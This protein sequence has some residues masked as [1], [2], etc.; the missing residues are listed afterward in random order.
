V[1]YALLFL[2][3]AC[4]SDAID[5]DEPQDA[6]PDGKTDGPTQSC[7]KVKCGNPDADAILFPGNLGCTTGCE[8]GLAANDLYI[9]PTNGQPW[10]ETYDLGVWPARVLSGY[11]SGRIALLRR[12]AFDGDG[13]HAVMLDPSWNDGARDFLGDGPRH[14]EDIVEQWLEEDETRT[15]TLIYS[16]RSTGWANYAALQ[17]RAVGERVKV[18]K[19]TLP[20]MLVPTAPKIHDA[21]VDPVDWN[22]GTCTWGKPL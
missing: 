1:R 8:R 9:P 13:E 20:H 17:K 11:S 14:G 6:V 15:F 10:G 12:L 5:L 21:L 16:T 22:N 2:L 7:A 18:C 3:A 4:A 19:V